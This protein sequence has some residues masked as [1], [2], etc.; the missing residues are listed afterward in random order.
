MKLSLLVIAGVVLTSI[1]GI[2]FGVTFLQ[3]S[4]PDWLGYLL[5]GSAILL[6]TYLFMKE[7]FGYLSIIFFYLVTLIVGIVLVLQ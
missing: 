3:S 1:G 6:F 2:V 4:I 7:S 5:I